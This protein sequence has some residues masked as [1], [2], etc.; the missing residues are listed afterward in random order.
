MVLSVGVTGNIGSGKSTVCAIFRWLGVPIYEADVAAKSLYNT[1][2]G[3]RQAMVALFG[4]GVYTP[5]GV[6]D[7]SFVR[8]R[9]FVDAHLMERLNAVI[10]PIVFEDFAQWVRD[11]E[12]EGHAYVIKEAAILFESGADATVD[13][14]VGVMASPEI[15]LRRVMDRDGVDEAAFARR[16]QAQW[17]QERWKDRCDFLIYNDGEASLIEQVMTTHRQLLTLSGRG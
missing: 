10:H 1:H 14:V 9:V 4:D 3:L 7:A 8:E 12:R 13:R 16:V 2:A 6:F 15:R 11:R 5:E 17:P